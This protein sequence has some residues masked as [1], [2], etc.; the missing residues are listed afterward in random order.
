MR[1]IKSLR[2]M[3]WGRSTALLVVCGLVA[4]ALA[5]GGVVALDAQGYLVPH[6]P[7]GG[8]FSPTDLTALE[9]WLDVSDSAL[10]DVDGIYQITD[11]SGQGNHAVQSTG[12]EKPI[13]NSASQ[14]GLDTMS[15]D[16][17]DD[18]IHFPVGQM[19]VGYTL[20][21]AG[22][23]LQTPNNG[24]AL[25]G[26]TSNLPRIGESG[27]AQ[28]LAFGGGGGRFGVTSVNWAGKSLVG[29]A[30]SAGAQKTIFYNDV[31]TAKRTTPQSRALLFLRP[32]Y[33]CLQN[34]IIALI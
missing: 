15:T 26:T 22:E 28:L 6:S 27:A 23:H 3:S 13:L 14:N 10:T 17:I 12:S 9:V 30:D 32:K 21:V 19:N 5:F 18:K 8:A 29:Y 2:E 1:V 20:Y 24:T 11:K 33:I 25:A 7:R 34:R 31:D 16:E 4:A